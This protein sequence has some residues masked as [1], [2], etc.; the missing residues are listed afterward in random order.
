MQRG[1]TLGS[2][3]VVKHHGSGSGW[4]GGWRVL[5]E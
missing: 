2:G 1:L 4:G 5:D 3:E